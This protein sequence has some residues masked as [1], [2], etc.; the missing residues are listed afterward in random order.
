VK[1]QKRSR[2]QIYFD[3]LFCL[4]RESRSGLKVTPTT[5]AHRSNVPYDRFQDYLHHLIELGLVAHGEETL[6]VTRK[7]L[8]Y[9]EEFAKTTELLK[10]MGLL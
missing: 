9:I 6:A 4:C 3:I 8:E 10:R 7:G 5:L 2:F 1:V